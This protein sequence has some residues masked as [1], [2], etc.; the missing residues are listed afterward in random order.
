MN[1]R[2]ELDVCKNTALSQNTAIC[3]KRQAFEDSG[4][5]F[6]TA[7]KKEEQNRSRYIY[8]DSLQVKREDS[9]IRM[10]EVLP[11][12][13]HY[14]PLWG[15]SGIL[16]LYMVIIIIIIIIIIFVV[17]IIMR[18]C[19]FFSP[20]CLWLAFSCWLLDSGWGGRLRNRKDNC[21]VWK[22][23]AENERTILY[24][25]EHPVTWEVEHK[26]F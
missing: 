16:S 1:P 12:M 8:V 21:E 25:M 13:Y 3:S 11:P 26:P 17:I 24:P 18:I 6:D 7:S 14:S 22:N 19:M 9:P 10:D 20:Y 4:C 23:H 15:G 2:L 5:I